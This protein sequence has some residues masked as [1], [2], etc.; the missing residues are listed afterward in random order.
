ML[1]P[2]ATPRR[3]ATVFIFIVV[4]IDMLSIGIIA[5][6]LPKLIANFLGGNIANAAVYQGAFTTVWALGQFFCS[7][8]LGM[9]SDK[10]GRR[11]VILISCLVTAIDF[12]IMAIAPNLWWLFAGRILSGVATANLSTAYA[13]IADVTTHENRAKAYGLLSSAFGIGFVLGPAIGGLAGNVDARLPFWIAA[14]FSLVN[15]LYGFFVLPESLKPEHRTAKVDWKRANPVGSLKMLL[16]HRELYGLSTVNFIV[17]VAHDAL[18]NLW[19]LYLIA[20]FGWDQRSIGLSLALVG[21]CSAITASTLVGPAVKRFGERRTLV[22]GLVVYVI[23]YVM[24]GINNGY[25]FL[26]AIMVACLSI[27]NSPMQ[28]LMTK[29]VGPQEQGELQG[30]MGAVRGIAALIGPFLFT[31]MF[32]QFAGPWRSY[33]LLGAPFFFAAGLGAIGLAIAIRVTTREDDVVMPL[34]EPL[35]ITVIEGG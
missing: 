9:L 3:G 17:L 29:R 34:P 28:S 15:W 33:N 25:V 22:M 12:A 5:P 35:P 26:I 16:R 2:N 4:T 20:Q 19:V 21:V 11:P 1:Q 6:V 13:Y 10:V 30:A 23:G 24:F 31:L 32:Y 27:Y 7:P 14:G 8:L 18:P